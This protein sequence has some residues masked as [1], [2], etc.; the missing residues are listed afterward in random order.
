MTKRDAKALGD[1]LGRLMAE[2]MESTKIEPISGQLRRNS[3]LPREGS[4]EYEK[5]P[6]N[7]SWP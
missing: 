2:H 3:A 4:N 7:I 1:E 6:P 5:C